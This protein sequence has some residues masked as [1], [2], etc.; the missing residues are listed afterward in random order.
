VGKYYEPSRGART[1]LHAWNSE[2]AV[3]GEAHSSYA[4]ALNHLT[5]N[6]SPRPKRPRSAAKRQ[7][8][9][10]AREESG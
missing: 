8:A 9:P 2:P 7:Q 5:D 10:V 1:A 6:V 3:R 4:R